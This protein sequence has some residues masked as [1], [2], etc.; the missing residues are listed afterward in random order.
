MKTLFH[1]LSWFRIFFLCLKNGK[2]S[3]YRKNNYALQN[4][5][6]NQNSLKINVISNLTLGISTTFFFWPLPQPVEV[7]K[8]G[9]KHV[10]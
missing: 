3:K 5:Q 10:P 4:I 7:S 8:L 2:K 1:W 6:K 9:I